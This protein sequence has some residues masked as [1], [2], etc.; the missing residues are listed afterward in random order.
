MATVSQDD[1]P[2]VGSVLHCALM[3]LSYKSSL[4]EVEISPG[5]FDKANTKGMESLLHFLLTKLR[6]ISQ[7]KKAGFGSVLPVVP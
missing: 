1:C 7:S 5:M 4:H 2:S 3:L 6:G